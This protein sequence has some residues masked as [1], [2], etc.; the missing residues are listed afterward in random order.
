MK[1]R[2][3]SVAAVLTRWK[4]PGKFCARI[5]FNSRVAVVPGMATTK[6][7][8]AVRRIFL[9]FPFSRLAIFCFTGKFSSK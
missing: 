8:E 2:L 1:T 4:S 3:A 5:A 9:R 6:K 7:S